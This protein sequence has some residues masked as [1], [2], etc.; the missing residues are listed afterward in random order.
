MIMTKTTGRT[1]A[2]L[3]PVLLTLALPSAPAAA[4]GS[5]PST[6]YACDVSVVPSG[7]PALPLLTDV[8]PKAN[9]TVGA[10]IAFDSIPKSAAAGSDVTLKG[11]ISFTYSTAVALTSRLQFA[12]KA[13]VGLTS[14]PMA[15]TGSGVN[16]TLE[17][18]VTSHPMDAIPPTAPFVLK[19]P[20]TAT[21]SVPDDATDTL[22]IT[23][24]PKTL[25]TQIAQDS[26]IEPARGIE[27]GLASGKPATVF[28]LKVSSAKSDATD[29]GATTL[30]GGN[31]AT[32]AG[33]DASLPD[34]APASDTPPTA[35]TG[36][37]T[38]N[39]STSTAAFQVPPNTMT[40]KTFVP[41][42]LVILMAL[43]TWWASRVVI[44]RH[45]T[46]RTKLAT[47]RA[48]HLS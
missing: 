19:A 16:T 21:L 12:S 42:W 9:E 27:C 32:G 13:G 10:A 17:P 46:Y 2:A 3:S 40:G 34:G 20:V 22:T 5:A 1:L 24:P 47:A 45:A 35:S 11:T 28:T 48:R 6:D 36:D 44:R 23:L 14:F 15:V 18:K 7:V 33:G 25:F 4:A 26:P 39:A 8:L 38:S 41:Y 29:P 37:N 43:L 30:P 31:S